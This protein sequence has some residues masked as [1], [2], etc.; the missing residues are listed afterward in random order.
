MSEDIIS[1]L[2]TKTGSKI[3]MVV[4]DGLGDVGEGGTITPLEEAE[5]PNLDAFARES[6]LG[7]TIPLRRGITPGSGPAHLSLFGYDGIFYD[8]GRGLL[9]ALGLGFKVLPGDLCL[10]L[11]FCTL[12]N[13]V[14]IDR[15]AGR[16]AT[17]ENERLLKILE[18][19]ISIPG[20]SLF[21][22]T[23]KEH[24]AVLI[25]RGKDLSDEI[26]DTDPQREGLPILKSEAKSCGECSD[27]GCVSNKIST[28]KIINSISMGVTKAFEKEKANGVLIRGASLY[29]ELP[30]FNEKFKLNSAAIAVYPMYRGLASLVGMTVISDIK[31]NDESLQ[32]LKDNFSK[33]DFFFVHFKDADKHGEDGNYDAKKK[34]LEEIDKKLGILRELSI[35]TLIICGDHST[36]AC[37]S[38]HSFHP[39]PFMIRSKLARRLY[40]PKSFCERE[41]RK[42]E[43]GVF[44]AQEIMSYALAYSGKLKKFGA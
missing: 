18:K 13:G 43:L 11:N 35:D 25:I 37:M 3:V 6:D 28:A 4:F 7:L 21:W 19:N 40:K 27:C 38:G 29:R 36:P 12:S 24:R 9:S 41:C 23:E 33:Y 30:S 10:R 2:A 8:V 1:E 42:G 15:R 26:T 32:A 5:T 14:I 16:I 17:E 34:C 22:L 44:P 20:M 31:N 39:V